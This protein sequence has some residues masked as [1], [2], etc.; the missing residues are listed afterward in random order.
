MRR[1][2][3]VRTAA[4]LLAA[5][6]AGYAA[7][8]VARALPAPEPRR[9]IGPWGEP[10]ADVVV[11]IDGSAA[12]ARD[13]RGREVARSGDRELVWSE[14]LS[15]GS[16]VAFRGDFSDTPI[17]VPGG[18]SVV[19]FGAQ[20]SSLGAV[21]V[22]GGH[23]ELSGFSCRSLAIDA[24]SD[25]LGV[26][27]RSLRVVGDGSGTGIRMGGTGEIGGVILDAV[28]VENHEVCIEVAAPSTTLHLGT[29]M[30][31]CSRGFYRGYGRHAL[32]MPVLDTVD[33]GFDLVGSAFVYIVDPVFRSVSTMFSTSAEN[34]DEP[35][36]YVIGD[37]FTA[38]GIAKVVGDGSTKEF[39][40]EVQHGL[41]S[42]RVAVSVSSTRPTTAPPSYVYGYVADKDSDGF[43][44]TLVITVRFDTAPA[45]G[46]EIELFW[47][48][49]VVH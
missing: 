21:R 34:G 25:L 3:A 49:E 46:E 22:T 13:S 35:Q 23:V 14:A 45:D 44:E 43:A 12:V 33:T 6:L 47:R 11:E 26:A 15:R 41:V 42:D 38:S 2:E 9:F 29:H 36:Y 48:A 4:A 32:I 1:R 10:W 27:L 17:E 24:Q 8:R 31:M 20:R 28:F 19:G 18:V 5:A 39:V 16:V 37:G 40:V 30:I 7:G